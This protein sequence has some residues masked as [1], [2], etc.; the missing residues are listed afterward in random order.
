MPKVLKKS[1]VHFQGSVSLTERQ[2]R[3]CSMAVADDYDS[4]AS[5]LQ[6]TLLKT[7]IATVVMM[8]TALL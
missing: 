1:S 5:G 6:P 3:E 2:L 4:G 7:V 8:I